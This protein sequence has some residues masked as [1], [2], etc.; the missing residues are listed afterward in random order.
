MKQLFISNT[1]GVYVRVDSMIGRNISSTMDGGGPTAFW[2]HDLASSLASTFPSTQ[3]S[4]YPMLQ[5]QSRVSKHRHRTQRRTPHGLESLT[6]STLTSA[7]EVESKPK[8]LRKKRETARGR[9]QGGCRAEQ[10]DAERPC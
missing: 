9:H 1:G 4:N 5:S 3:L 2:R 8:S 6:S 10:R 7:S